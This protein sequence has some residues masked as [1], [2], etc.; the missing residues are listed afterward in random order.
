MLTKNP[1]SLQWLYFTVTTTINSISYCKIYVVPIARWFELQNNTGGVHLPT[2]SAAIARMQEMVRFCNLGISN[3]TGRS[4]EVGPP[5]P[6][7]SNCTGW[8]LIVWCPACLSWGP[9]STQGFYR[10]TNA[11][12]YPST[13][14]V[15]PYS[16]RR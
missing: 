5:I 1:A 11:P 15:A 14:K 8:M 6:E 2:P 9:M 16:G 12:A 7:K 10:G 3:H 13:Q 4:E